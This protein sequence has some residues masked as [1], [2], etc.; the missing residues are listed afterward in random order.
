M[1]RDKLSHLWR[2]LRKNVFCKSMIVYVIIAELIFWSPV[3]VTAILALVIS[4]WWWTVVTAIILFWT[5]PFTP[6]VPLQIALALSL[7]LIVTRIKRHNM[8]K[9]VL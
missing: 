2:W 5:G 1:I 4:P 6:A 9:W 3:I 8:Y 7:K